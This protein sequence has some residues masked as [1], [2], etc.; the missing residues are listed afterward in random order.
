LAQQASLLKDD[1]LDAVDPLLED[2]QLVELVR[3][4]LAGRRPKSNR[5]GRSGIA[6]DRLLRCCVLKHVKG[7]SFLEL[8]RELGSNLIY[9]C[10]R[11]CKNVEI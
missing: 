7:W 10:R 2:A 1:L 6:P 3:Q 9:R 4:C 11:A 8:E 5:T